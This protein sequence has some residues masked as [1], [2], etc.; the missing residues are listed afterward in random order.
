MTQKSA[1]NLFIILYINSILFFS[2]IFVFHNKNS[3]NRCLIEYLMK[4]PTAFLRL[5]ETSK[6][7]TCRNNSTEA[8]RWWMNYM[9]NKQPV[10]VQTPVTAKNVNIDLLVFC[11]LKNQRW[12]PCILN[13]NNHTLFFFLNQAGTNS[14]TCCIDKCDDIFKHQPKW[15]PTVLLWKQLKL[16]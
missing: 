9:F 12:E 16:R 2:P 1:W 3:Q 13:T 4:W 10:D 15:L 8:W 5:S 6:M 14:C 11:K 7:E